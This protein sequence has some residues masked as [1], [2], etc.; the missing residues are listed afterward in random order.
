MLCPDLC[1]LYTFSSNKLVRLVAKGVLEKTSNWEEPN[2]C[3]ARP[4]EESSHAW[5][6]HLGPFLPWVHFFSTLFLPPNLLYYIAH[7]T[8]SISRSPF[9]L[10]L[11]IKFGFYL[12][13]STFH[14]KPV[15]IPIPLI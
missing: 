3:K 11:S 10:L 4:R 12:L 6:G 7:P 1:D 13:Y 5:H 8:F 2:R 15:I 14:V 9:S